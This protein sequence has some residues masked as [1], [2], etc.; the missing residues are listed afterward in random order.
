MK[1]PTQETQKDLETL[2]SKHQLLPVL[3]TAFGEICEEDPFTSEALAQIYLHRQADPETMVGLLS[4]KYG[5]PDDVAAGLEQLVE[6]EFIDW[7]SQK[8]RFMVVFDV[9]PEIQAMLDRY[10]YPLPMVYP[11]HKLKDNLDTGYETIRKLAVL[12]GSD[13]FH[14]VDVC[15]DHLN[16]ANSVGLQL[17]MRVVQASEGRFVKPTRNPGEDFSDFN[18]RLR[19]ANVFYDTSLDVMEGL[20]KLTDTLY[21]THRY[22]R[23]GRCYASGYHISTQ[24]DDYRKAVLQFAKKEVVTS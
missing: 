8:E 2:Y 21:L 11:P 7:D 19:Q 6:E 18:K 24:G 12:N 1:N 9:T 4:P 23:R 16:R 13:Y 3:K 20:N 15:R 10:Q 14:D 5:S 17:D 22:D